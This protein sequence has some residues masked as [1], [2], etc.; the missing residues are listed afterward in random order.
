MRCFH[1]VP[2]G[3]DW[4]T[5]GEIELAFIKAVHQKQPITIRASVKE[6][7]EVKDGALLTLAF[8]IQQENGAINVKGRAKGIIKNGGREN[9]LSSQS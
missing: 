2:F 4:F 6:K 7:I 3:P 8:R 5:G 9:L 1:R